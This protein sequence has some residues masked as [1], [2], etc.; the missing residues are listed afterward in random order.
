MPHVGAISPTLA[1]LQ[2]LHRNTLTARYILFFVFS[3][4][5]LLLGR[6]ARE[7]AQ[8]DWHAALFIGREWRPEA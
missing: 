2:G 5:N 4:F 6:G 1:A 8:P 7:A 3:G